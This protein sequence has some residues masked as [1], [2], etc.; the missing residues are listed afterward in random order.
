MPATVGPTSMFMTGTESSFT[1]ST[2]TM[3][4]KDSGVVVEVQGRS[5]GSAV[6]ATRQSFSSSYEIKASSSEIR[7][8]SFTAGVSST[9][10]TTSTATLGL[11]AAG[12]VTTSPHTAAALYSSEISRSPQT[13]VAELM[14][15]P[16]IGVQLIESADK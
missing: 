1:P 9:S 14:I 8:S 3:I 4:E 10:T 2:S 12:A 5:S 15:E 7:S 16:R 11:G 6:S 13:A